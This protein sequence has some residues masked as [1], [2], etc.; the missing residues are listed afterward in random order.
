MT[1]YYVLSLSQIP[2]NDQEVFRETKGDTGKYK[3]K[4]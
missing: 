2:Y 1:F 3:E 4:S